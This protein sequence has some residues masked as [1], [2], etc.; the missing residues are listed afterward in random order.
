MNYK[1]NKIVVIC[2]LFIL[3]TI[4]VY[5]QS[6]NNSTEIIT[7]LKDKKSEKIYELT[8]KDE[9]DQNIK[10]ELKEVKGTPELFVVRKT[11][12][13]FKGRA[14]DYYFYK[15]NLIQSVDVRKTNSQRFYYS[16]NK[17]LEI[18]PSSE[19]ESERN[20]ITKYGNY[21]K[22][23]CK[24]YYNEID[25]RYKLSLR[26]KQIQWENEIEI[27][28]AKAKQEGKLIL[29]TFLDEKKESKEVEELIFS[30][31]E[32]IELAEQ[33]KFILLKIKNKK[34]LLDAYLEENEFSTVIKNPELIDFMYLK[35]S[36][37]P[38]L[39]IQS[40]VSTGTN[41][42]NGSNINYGNYLSSY[43]SFYYL[44]EKTPVN[45]L[46]SPIL[47]E[48]N[49]NIGSHSKHEVYYEFSDIKSASPERVTSKIKS[50]IAEYKPEPLSPFY[51]LRVL[52]DNDLMIYGLKSLNI[53]INKMKSG[54][55]LAM[56][57]A[58]LGNVEALKVLKK[59]KADFSIKNKKGLTAYDFAIQNNKTSASNYLKS[60]R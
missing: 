1:K 54:K 5:A 2:I 35:Y 57:A 8:T 29:V 28:I 46:F 53:D 47:K 31:N 19:L 60:I 39:S 26:G 20:R 58:E 51:A 12:I 13:P 6:L 37:M 7:F 55:T 33:E 36:L 3:S 9:N 4:A 17:L 14:F 25:K 21:I 15:G 49:A 30:S 59:N 48:E 38:D 56:F 32:F 45:F 18:I 11:P 23:A 24:D 43:E 50:S 42:S 22:V 10:L 41:N 27:A 34:N 16:Q 52:H 40:Q 44:L